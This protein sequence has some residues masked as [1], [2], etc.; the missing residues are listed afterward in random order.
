MLNIKEKE[1]F[2]YVSLG[3]DIDDFPRDIFPI[4]IDGKLYDDSNQIKDL[5]NK[6]S[7]GGLYQ[8]STENASMEVS[9]KEN[10]D[11]YTP[12]KLITC[13]DLQKDLN[14]NNE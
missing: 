10:E 14:I 3:G 6:L 11:S 7:N 2:D 8:S 9:T 12:N 13:E 1:L 4:C 5:L